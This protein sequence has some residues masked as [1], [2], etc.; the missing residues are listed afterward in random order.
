MM[1]LETIRIENGLPQNLELHQKRLENTVSLPI[2]LKKNILVPVA[3]RTGRV[4]CRIVY[5][6]EDIQEI[7][8]THYTPKKINRLKAV[9]VDFDYHLKYADRSNIAFA[10]QQ[11]GD[12]DDILMI[13]NGLVTDTSYANVVVKIDDKLWTPSK[14]LLKGVKRLELLTKGDIL[15]REIT[16][17]DMQKVDAIF[18]INAMLNIGEVEISPHNIF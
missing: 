14:P 13:K 1:F 10:M 5:N 12:C 4:K 16:L 2:D 3:F 8:Y 15:E 17:Q 18:L 7:K 11:K 6:E 9:D